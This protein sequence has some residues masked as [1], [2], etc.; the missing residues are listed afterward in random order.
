MIVI[1]LATLTMCVIWAVYY[2]YRIAIAVE[3]MANK[4]KMTPEK[5]KRIKPFMELLKKSEGEQYDKIL[6]SIRRIEDE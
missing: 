4:G 2:L 1:Q 3:K 5:V 6:E